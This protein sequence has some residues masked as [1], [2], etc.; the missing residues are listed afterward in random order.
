MK[1]SIKRNKRPNRKMKIVS[2]TRFAMS[3]TL[4][5]VFI[6]STSMIAFAALD[7]NGSNFKT[8][9]TSEPITYT[10]QSG[11]SLWSIASNI[12]KEQFNQEKDIRKI[13]YAIRKTNKLSSNTIYAGQDLKLPNKSGAF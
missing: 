13:I 10:V 3:M 9:E 1:A 6:L 4:I 5:F 2:K 11:D 7:G 8:V 12:N